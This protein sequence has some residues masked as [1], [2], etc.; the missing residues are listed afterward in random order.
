MGGEISDRKED[1][2]ESHK[3]VT[4]KSLGGG[5]IFIRAQP[6]CLRVEEEG[7][8]KRKVQ[9]ELPSRTNGGKKA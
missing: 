9:T 5:G 3:G 8:R 1:K 6:A 2:E 4:K 7:I